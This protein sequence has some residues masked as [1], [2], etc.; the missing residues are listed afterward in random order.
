[1]REVDNTVTS[2]VARDYLTTESRRHLERMHVFVL[3][4]FLYLYM[5]QNQNQT[6]LFFYLQNMATSDGSSVA[7]S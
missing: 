2:G 6:V 4:F 7:L 5:T 1:M 3:I